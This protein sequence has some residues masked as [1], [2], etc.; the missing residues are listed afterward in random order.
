MNLRL[1]ALLFVG[2]LAPTVPSVAQDFE[3]FEVA[4]GVY[5]FR[6]NSH[7]GMFVHSA[8]EVVVF[9]PI[10]PAA[11][12]A[13][14]GE[15]QRTLPGARLA[16]IVY[17][18][19]DADHS[20]GATALMAAFGG[21]VVP[22]IAHELAVAPIAAR[23]DANH[24]VPTVTFS[25]RMAFDIGGRRIELHYLGPSHTD[26]MLV[27]F[28]P[29]VGVAFAVDFVALDRVG[30]QGLPGWRFPEFFGAL[31]GMLGI[32]FQTVVFGHGPSGDRDAIRRQIG[33]YDDLTSAMRKALS[34]GLTEDQAVGQ[35]SLPKYQAW[36]QYQAWM[37]MNARAIYQWLANG[38]R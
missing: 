30:Y 23:A 5:R 35:V 38:G 24:P 26:N 16:A 29:D 12:T 3:T 13:F 32:P 20:A 21:A 33:Y 10:N 27:G 14:A 18:H 31:S 8:G 25:E 28:V 4:D 2:C 36:D 34:N 6:W 22:I 17:S 15:V 19:S 7:N 37:P 1:K 11:A 9:D